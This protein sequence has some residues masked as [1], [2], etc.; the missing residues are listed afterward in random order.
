VDTPE[1]VERLSE[2]LEAREGRGPQ[3][4]RG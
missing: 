4:G 2:Y 1:D 3:E